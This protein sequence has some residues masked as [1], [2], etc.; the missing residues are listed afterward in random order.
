MKEI[1]ILGLYINHRLK[2]ASLLQNTLSKYG[3]IIKTRLGL[4]DTN[5]LPDANGST[6]SLIILEITGTPNE[7]LNL[8]NELMNIDGLQVDRMLFITGDNI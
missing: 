2:D 7:I 5:A 3:C 1:R 4:N 8:E 6:G